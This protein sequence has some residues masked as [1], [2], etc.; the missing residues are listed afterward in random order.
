MAVMFKSEIT[1]EVAVCQRMR[2]VG[3]G[4]FGNEDLF[5][6]HDPKKMGHRS[7]MSAERRHWRDSGSRCASAALTCWV[8]GSSD[9]HRLSSPG[10][11]REP[12]P[13]SRQSRLTEGGPE[14]RAVPFYFGMW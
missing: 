12:A 8:S 3:F 11:C 6:V 2:T 4:T 14:I 1:G 5:L 7:A 9:R 10:I 13:G